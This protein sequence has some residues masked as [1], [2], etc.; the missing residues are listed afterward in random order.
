MTLVNENGLPTLIAA[1]RA[2]LDYYSFAAQ[3]ARDAEVAD[4]FAFAAKCRAQLLEGLQVRV[5]QPAGPAPTPDVT[6][7]A[8]LRSQFDPAHPELQGHALLQRERQ[9]VRLVESSF[10]TESSLAVRRALK[11][12]Y[13]LLLKVQQVMQRLAARGGGLNAA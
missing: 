8:Q 13:P 5:T 4:A 12:S 7:Y 3:E 9:L 1:L 2:G 11:E 10:R 6:A